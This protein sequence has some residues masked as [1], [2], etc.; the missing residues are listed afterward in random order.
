VRGGARVNELRIIALPSVAM[1][2]DGDDLVT[3]FLEALGASALTLEYRDLVI[4][5]S[6]VVSKS[7]GQVV[8]FDGTEEHKVAL[9]EQESIRILR[10]RGPLR[11][12]ETHHGFINANA[13]IDLS[14]TDDGTAVLLPKDPD[15]SARR[16]RAE[17]QRRSGVEVAVIITDTFGRVWRVGVTDVAIGSSGVKPILDLRGTTDASG[18]VLEVTE[19]A[20]ADE[21]AS[22]ANLVLGKA[23]ATPFAIVRGL[24]DSYFG[25]GSIK[26]NALRRPNEDLFR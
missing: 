6:K 9:I 23:A 22:A 21:I 8:D 11:I 10:R 26:D 25:E 4:V 16:F 19:V 17:I 15:R 3:M 24:D 12:T 20:I 5:T 7:E 2:H 13:G 14:N 1:V 18:R